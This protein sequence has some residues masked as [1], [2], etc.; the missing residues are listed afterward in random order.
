MS[1][2][3]IL[4]LNLDEREYKINYDKRN[5]FILYA[6]QAPVILYLKMNN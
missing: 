5:I 4:G 1:D 6:F 3:Y 2:Q